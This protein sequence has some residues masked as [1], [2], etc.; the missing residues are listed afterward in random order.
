[1]ISQKPLTCKHCPFAI[2]L[3]TKIGTTAD[4]NVSEDFA[5]HQGWNLLKDHIA[6]AHPEYA[7]QLSEWI[8]GSTSH[9]LP[10]E[11]IEKEVARAQ[12]ECGMEVAA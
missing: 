6:Q 7:A 5:S 11:S 8:Y 9:K 12:R 2:T 3:T 1:M 4:A 10:F